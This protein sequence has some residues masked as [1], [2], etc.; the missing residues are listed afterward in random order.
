MVI[1]PPQSQDHLGIAPNPHA[2]AIMFRTRRSPQFRRGLP[3]ISVPTSSARTVKVASRGAYT[4][5]RRRRNLWGRNMREVRMAVR[6]GNFLL[7]ASL[8]A[9]AATSVLGQ[10]A[11]P[12]AGAASAASQSAASVPDLSQLWANSL[13]PGFSP[14]ASGPSPVLNKARA[15]AAVEM[16]GKD[17]PPENAPIVSIGGPRVGDHTA[18]ILPTWRAET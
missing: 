10:A 6:R 18:P 17:I 4:T 3:S 2:D 14:P 9:T 11:A 12:A 8:A 1:A 13:G 15:R 16:Y 5:K 7:L